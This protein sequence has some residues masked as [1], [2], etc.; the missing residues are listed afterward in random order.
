MEIARADYRDENHIGWQNIIG[1]VTSLLPYDP[2][3]LSVVGRFVDWCVHS[4]PIGW[5]LSEEMTNWSVVGARRR[6]H[7]FFFERNFL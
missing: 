2:V 3:C 1:I 4:T 7:N 6:K 5:P